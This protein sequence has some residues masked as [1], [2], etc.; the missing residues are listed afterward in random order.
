MVCSLA[1]FLHKQEHLKQALQQLA[2]NC[3]TISLLTW[4]A[5][6]VVGVMSECEVDN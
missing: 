5:F 3:C 1:L 4:V 2:I 6:K